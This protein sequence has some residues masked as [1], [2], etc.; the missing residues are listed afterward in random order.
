MWHSRKPNL[1][2]LKVF[3]SI[4]YVHQKLRKRKFDEKSF[5]AILVGY[6]PNGYRLWDFKARKFFVGRDVIVDEMN[7]WSESNELSLPSDILNE[8]KEHGECG[9]LN[10]S[11]NSDTRSDILNESKDHGECGSLKESQ[12]C[13]NTDQVDDLNDSRDHDIC[14][15]KSVNDGSMQNDTTDKIFD[16]FV[17][18]DH[19]LEAPAGLKKSDVRQ[20][21]RLK[22]KPL[23]S[24]RFLNGCLMNADSINHSIPKSFDEIKN[25]GDSAY[26]KKA[27]KQELESHFENE[28]WTIVNKPENKNVVDSKWVFSIKHDEFG[29]PTKYKARL[30]AR[31]FT[32]EYMLDYEETFAPVARISSLR[33]ILALSN[34]FDLQVH[35]MDVKTAFLNGK[36][37]EEI[38]MFVPQGLSYGHDKVC[39]LNKALYGLKQAARCW[40]EV[41]E[42]ALKDIGFVNSEV[43]RCIYINDKRDISKNIYVLLYVD[44]VVIATENTQ[45]MHKF[46]SYL[47]GKFKM[48]DLMEIKFFIGIKIDRTEE[49]LYLSQSAYIQNILNRFNMQDCK[50]VSTPLANN[51]DY[52]ALSSEEECDT[53]CRSLIG[54]L[55]YIMLCTRPDLCT[56]VS[57]LSRYTNKNNKELW[58]CLKRVLRYL[59]GTIDLK[60]TFVKNSN[61]TNVVVGYADSDWAGSESDRRSTTGFVFNMFDCNL[62]CW[63]SRKQNSVAASSTE[64]EYMAL[65]EAVREALWIKSLMQGIKFNVNKAIK[66]YEDNQGCISIANNPTCHKRTKHIDIKYHFSREQISNKIITLEYIPTENQLADIMTKPLPA[67]RFLSLRNQLGLT[68]EE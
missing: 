46:K 36:L 68:N 29:S 24:Y 34:Q 35:H 25:R 42:R 58:Q 47:M 37:K 17:T 56:S 3:G 48:T 41:F 28:T 27:I 18:D 67:A 59:K 10:E 21:E 65:F 44:D 33:L 50:S 12:E 16:C 43:D 13:A 30:V 32:Q 39:K 1:K 66:I 11:K 55:M 23:K 2:Y 60:L 49:K 19:P 54:C 52:E 7:S 15:E 22:A 40:F 61:Y 53:P 8:S 26:W 62:V 4:V 20:S 51:L 6:E 5:K 38:Y 57:I 31:G 9:I 63:N 64:A 14:N 45:T